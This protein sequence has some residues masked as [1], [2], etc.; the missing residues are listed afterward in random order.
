MLSI[1]AAIADERTRDV[2]NQIFEDQYPRMKRI[3]RDIL[4]NPHDAEDAAMTAVAHICEHPELF[5]EYPSP[6]TVNLI[7]VITRNAAKDLYRRNK[8]RRATFVLNDDDN[9]I[10]EQVPDDGPS[11]EELAVTE[12]NREMLLRAL[13]S[14]DDLYRIPILLRY[15]HR[16]KNIE[17]AELLGVDANTVNGRIFR[18]KRLLEQ[19]MKDMGYTYE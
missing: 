16:M 3:A 15:Y 13:A 1:I 5:E 18:A 4:R 9:P 14:L 12:E 10:L 19:A 2:L 7:Y 6:K 8:C 11:V 17:I